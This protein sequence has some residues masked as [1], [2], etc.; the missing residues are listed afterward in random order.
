[1]QAVEAITGPGVV[2]VARLASA[3]G[4]DEVVAASIRGGARAVEV[5]M[6]TPGGLDWLAGAVTRFDPATVALGVGTVLSTVDAKEAIDAGAAFLVSPALVEGLVTTAHD[7]GVAVVP[8]AFTPTELLSAWQSG[9]DLVKLFPARVGGPAYVKDVLGPFTDLPIL[10]TGGIDAGNAEAYTRAGVRAVGMGGAAVS[11]ATVARG[12]FDDI[13]AAVAA[14]V[15]A[16]ARGR[17]PA[18]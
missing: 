13:E 7:A 18:R 3:A 1:M 12:A 2:V 4:L 14:T 6:N 8:G 9:A 17:Q 11:S 5:T 10:A 15:A 16:V